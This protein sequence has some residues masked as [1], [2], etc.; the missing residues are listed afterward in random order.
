MLVKRLSLF[1]M[2]LPALFAACSDDAGGSGGV[3]TQV[4]VTNYVGSTY[5][6]DYTVAKDPVLRRIP[7]EWINKARTNFHIAYQH[8]SHGTHVAYGMF[9]L[10]GFK[11]GD[12]VRFGI[13]TPDTLDANRLEFHDLAMSA[14]GVSDLSSDETGFVQATRD[15]LNDPANNRINVVMWSWCSISGHDVAGN[16]LPGM[17]TLISEYGTNGSNP[18]ADTNAVQFIFMTGHAEKDANVGDG[19]PR[20][21]AALITNFCG[22]N[23]QFCLD[24]YSIDTHALNDTYYEDTGDDG[25]SATYGGLFYLDFQTAATNGVDWYY[26]RSSIGG[27][28]AVGVHNHQHI[29]ANRKAFAMWWILARLAGWDGTLEP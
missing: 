2:V 9:G 16:Y 1:L 29:T 15:F 26:N 10:P 18:R 4:V 17:A 19:Q 11:A 27:S 21:Q 20:N 14:S 12:D 5:I 28:V 7:L 22:A 24:Y 6:A 23:N 13:C 25:D 3:Y 8:T